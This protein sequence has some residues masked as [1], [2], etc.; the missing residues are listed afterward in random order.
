MT[1][2]IQDPKLKTLGEIVSSFADKKIKFAKGSTGKKL[3][4][5]YLKISQLRVS[6]NYQRFVQT[7]TLKK[8]KQFNHELCQPLFVALRPDG[9]YVIVDGQHKAIMAHLGELFEESLPCFVYKHDKDAS[10]T[11]CIEKESIL[12]ENLNT[13]RKNTSTLDKIRAGLSYNDTDSIQFENNFIAIG[14]KAEGIGYKNGPEVNGFAKAVESINKWKINNTKQAVDFLYPI[15]IKQWNCDNIDG[16]MIGGLAAVF[17]L[18]D[19][20]GKGKKEDGL[21]FYLKN[22]F[23]NVSKA[24][25]IENTRGNSD[26]LIARKIIKKYNDLVEQKVIDGAVIGEEMLSN[27]KLGK[28][29][30]VS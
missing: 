6:S 27:N 28:L 11:T 17:N 7:S 29:D 13:T 23:A 4:L 2:Y 20:L 21:Q 16:S 22:N 14:I 15:Y 30:E 25:W 9:I 18:I 12:F 3:E 8:A 10:L 19:A 26:V 1:T 24:K 5:V